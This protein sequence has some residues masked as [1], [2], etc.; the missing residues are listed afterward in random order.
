MKICWFGIYNSKYPRN[1]I[2]I[3]GLKANGVEIKE[4]HEDCQ[5][6]WR[7]LSLAKR[8]KKES[9]DCDLVY[10]AYP[11]NISVLVAKLFGKKL[12]VM[13]ALY[14]MY[15]AVVNDR[16]EVSRYHPRAMKLWFDDWLAALTSD[17][18]IA[19]TKAHV[20]YWSRLPFIASSK[21]K[22]I[23][24]GVQ[25]HIFYPAKTGNNSEK[26]IVS[27][28]GMYVPLQGIPK[29]IE[30]AKLLKDEKNIK[31]RIIGSGHSFDQISKLIRDCGLNNVE[32]IGKIPPEKVAEYS[33]E[34]DVILG[35]FG[36]T[37]KT[38]RVIPNKIYEGMALRKP[39]I[40][41]DTQSV[42]EIFTDEDIM[43]VKNDP[44]AIA[45]AILKLKNDGNLRRKLADNGYKK[46]MKLYS[47]KPI[48]KELLNF[49]TEMLI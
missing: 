13:D 27:F 42:R 12:V 40:S 33:N 41:T 45:D 47:P 30:T 25:D 8:I 43:L 22:V 34:A 16:Q 7:Y 35:V 26:F 23:Y 48:G 49:L 24:T 32:Q 9:R 5:Y 28:H 3:R 38:G 4:C 37:G 44:Q 20:K 1:D 18:M 21:M 17:C 15:D 14:S 6:R 46:V 2:L 10:A 39:V 31:F 19:D 11:S 36:D 29:I